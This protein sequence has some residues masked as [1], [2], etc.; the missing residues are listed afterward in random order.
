M[1]GPFCNLLVYRKGPIILL[2]ISVCLSL[3][4]QQTDTLVSAQVYSYKVLPVVRPSEQVAFLP[5]QVR[6]SN[7]VSELLR[8]FTGVQVKDYGG[9][10]GLKTINV[11]SLGS[12]HVGVFLDGIQ[13]DNAQNM[14]VDLGRFSV[15]GLSGVALYNAVKTQRLQTAKEY[16]SGA[17][18]HL[19]VEEPYMIWSDNAYKVRFRGGSFGTVNPSFQWNSR[20]GGMHLRVGAE[21]LAS[22][23]KYKYDYFGTPLVRE[24]GD[25]ASFRLDTRLSGMLMGGKW[26]LLLYGYGS[27]R[28]FPGPVIRRSEEFPFSAE[29]QADRDLFAQGGWTKDWTD[30]YS[31]AVR[32]KYSNNYIHYNTHPEKNPMALPYNLHYRQQSVY[33]SVAQSLGLTD[34]WSFDLSTDY[35]YN[36]LDSDV[37]QFVK[38]RRSVFT[39]ALA[40]LLTWE[41]FRAA[42]HIAYLG[43]WDFFDARNAGGWSRENKYRDSW[44]S[45]L[46]LFYRPL[47]W[48][49]IDAFVKRTYRMPSFNDL[50]YSLIGN[51]ALLPE[52]AAQAGADFRVSARTGAMDWEARLSPYY[53][54]VEQK[55][56]AIPT[57]SQFR[58]TMLNIGKVDI[59]GVDAKIEAGRD[60]GFADRRA[61]LTLRYTF[62]Q[63]LDHS[64]PGSLTWGNQIPYIPLHSGGID[65]SLQWERLSFSWDTTLTGERWS[66]T[67]NTD[68]YRIAP[69]SLSD[70]SIARRFLLEG[71]INGSSRDLFPELSVGLALNNIFNQS[72][73]I[74]QGYPMPGFNAMLSVE[75]SW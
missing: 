57:S 69:W 74:V 72:Y 7:Q 49:E 26:N 64:G 48:L 25:I 62:Q 59:T 44:M 34:F 61:E 14:Q 58:W 18:V 52:S 33:A 41:K 36:T 43:A 65:L 10:G 39:G 46:S 35:Q 4:A 70:V 19:V 38:P 51:S 3:A 42:A 68:D 71:L 22:N 67:A 28:G 37:G 1:P 9:V 2:L 29:R 47:R 73:Q 31:T 40:T 12:E 53:N 27:E 56:V 32:F 23:G 20:I 66:R 11:R 13:I 30:R 16:A 5:G 15:D 6:P 24:N 8:R 75:L 17:A 50:Y 63:A 55:I 60:L 45:S 21:F 54:H